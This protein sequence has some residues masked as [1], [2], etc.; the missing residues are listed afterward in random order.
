MAISYDYSKP[1]QKV[2][3]DE[4]IKNNMSLY[5]L[6]LLKYC[7]KNTQI[8]ISDSLTFNKNMV[9]GTGFPGWYMNIDMELLM[10]Y[11]TD[12]II[13]DSRYTEKKRY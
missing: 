5:N 7:D 11:H 9:I 3:N 10:N 12:I 1:A 8:L 13:L 4:L 2:N 6:P